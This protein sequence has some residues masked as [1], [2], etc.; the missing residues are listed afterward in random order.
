MSIQLNMIKMIENM[1]AQDKAK[2][3][4]GDAHTSAE[5]QGKNHL[6]TSTEKDR[7]FDLA[8]K[9]N[10]I[11][12]LN[13]VINCYRAVCFI[14]WDLDRAFLMYG[15]HADDL[16]RIIQ[17]CF[18]KG[19]AEDILR[20]VVYELLTE[21]YK[22]KEPIVDYEKKIDEEA[23]LIFTNSGFNK[24][25]LGSFDYFD[26]P[27]REHSYFDPK[28]GTVFG[29]PNKYIIEKFMEVISSVIT[30][31]KRKY[32]L[33]LVQQRAKIELL[34]ERQQGEV[35]GYEDAISEF[36]N[37]K[38]LFGAIKIYTKLNVNVPDNNIEAHDFIG[39]LGNIE[40]KVKLSE[41]Q[42]KECEKRVEDA[43]SHDL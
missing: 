23:D 14:L 38:G 42:K 30:Y 29:L 40:S 4:I 25:I 12:Y 28:I 20:E 5:S 16:Q 33:D 7:L 41:D 36:I 22:G 39:M 13:I 35:K 37:L 10:Q 32:E 6:L 2:I 43:L 19:T 27:L 26:P 31:R 15:I 18:I 9:Q 34:S 3:L 24:G 11:H 17:S 1:S 8:R 21:K